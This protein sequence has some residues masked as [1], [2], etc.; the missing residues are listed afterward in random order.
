[1][2]AAGLAALGLASYSV[3]LLATI[4]ASY[5]ATQVQSAM[6][7]RIEIGDAHGTLWRGSAR[8]RLAPTRGG[9]VIDRLE[10]RLAPMR[11]AQ[12]EIAFVTRATSDGIEA[13]AEIARGF[14][15]WRVRD[16]NVEGDASALAA[17]VPAVAPWRP[18]GRFT[19]ATPSLTI[20]G[21]EVRGGLDAEW[22]AAGTA[23]SEVRPLGSYRATWRAEN[24]P[25]KIVV[26]TLQGPL[27][28]T[29]E[30]STTPGMRIAFSG[31]A[32]AEAGAAKALE[33]LLDLMGPRRT[34]GARALEL[35]LQ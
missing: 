3:F 25:G 6:P 32:R 8:A 18:S 26:T 5:V 27:G 21:Q 20:A 35:R 23:L 10:W 9:P 1:M 30:G 24:G 4:P 16:A 22:R 33:P 12:G 13:S 7:G 15:Q 17:F 34:D 31:E 14:R 2:R 19:L 28:I 29:G 11:F